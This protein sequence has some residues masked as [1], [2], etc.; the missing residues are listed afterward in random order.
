VQPFWLVRQTDPASPDFVPGVAGQAA[1]NV[2]HRSWTTLGTVATPGRGV[3]DP[4][5]LVTACEV[6]PDGTRSGWSLD[7][8]IGADDRWH[9]PANEASVRQRLVGEAP[10]VETA[11]RIP[12]GDAVQRVYAI[13]ATAESPFGQPFLVVE[14]ENRSPV[15]FA[16]ALAVVPWHPLGAGRIDSIRL[17]GP[18]LS[19]N[20]VPAVLFPR[21]PPRAVATDG[22]VTDQV[23]GG[24]VSGSFDEVVAPGG[25]GSAAVIFPLPHTAVLRVALPLDVG[26]RTSVS[27][28]SAVPDAEQVAKG[29]EVQT[30]RGIR[31]T[32]PDDR[33]QGVVEAGRRH[34][35]LAHGGGDVASWPRQPIEWT[36]AV[37]VLDALGAYGFN[38]E[39]E[40]VLATIPER[41]ALD[42]SL[43]GPAGC[44]GANG[45]ALVAVARQWRLN[46]DVELADQ[47]VG[48]VA[49]AAHWI[50]K[51]RNA[52]RGPTFSAADLAWSVGGLLAAAAMLDDLGQP[53]VAADAR[54]F[55]AGA[56]EA[57]ATMGGV[58]EPEI[59]GVAVVDPVA[60]AGLSPIRTLALARRE[61]AAGDAAALERLSWV[62]AAAAPTAVWPEVV[63]PR[64]GGGSAGTGQHAPTGA[65]FLSFVR[66]LLVRETP[67]GGLAL[68]SL[69]PAGWA[70][71]GVE[72]HDAPTD[73]G[74]FSFGLRW[75]GDRPALLWELDPRPGVGDLDLTAP[76]LDP[77]WRGAGLRG[78][79]LL[80]APPIDVE[81]TDVASTD[82]SATEVTATDVIDAAVER[83]RTDPGPVAGDPGSSFS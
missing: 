1:L 34:L 64:T 12:S 63:H 62:L 58:P 7:W 40:Q 2:T 71:L 24:L 61:L 76:G 53:E 30:R 66:D 26:R 22:D 56:D 15:P 47:L 8:W 68:C 72:V 44:A 81:P 37:S 3:V 4:R 31:L 73:L 54:R 55:A 45:A 42:G 57:L 33:L 6:D 51:R 78:E 49:K 28:P 70:G 36:E 50:D 29:W 77:A 82:M 69:L 39:V 25:D 14:V 80:A 52:R 17:D 16:I 35:V 74:S 32:V 48:P 21:P 20:G 38:E 46:R 23:L 60:R 13:H 75:H 9:T 5:G 41:Q 18:S 27:Y 11:V 83:R 59:S 10:V 65:A 67:S 19:V 43:M 79:A